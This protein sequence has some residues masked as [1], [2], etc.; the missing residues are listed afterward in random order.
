M[1]M[2]ERFYLSSVQLMN[3]L[4]YKDRLYPVLIPNPFENSITECYINT[5]MLSRS[6][7]QLDKTCI[8]FT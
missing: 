8:A 3:I 4:W 7:I 1:V 2:M 6:C 5:S